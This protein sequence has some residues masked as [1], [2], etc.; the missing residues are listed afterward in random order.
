MYGD[1]VFSVM[2]KALR[3]CFIGDAI[4]VHE[5]DVLT[6]HGSFLSLTFKAYRQCFTSDVLKMHGDD[7]IYQ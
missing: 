3:Q 5:H 4:R 6:M 1:D 7:V 2:F